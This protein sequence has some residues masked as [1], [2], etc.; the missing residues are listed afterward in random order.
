MKIRKTVSAKVFAANRNNAAKS[1]G[2][3]TRSGKAYASQNAIKHGIFARELYIT[4]EETGEFEELRHDLTAQLV[5]Q[6][7][8]QK[9]A[10]EEIL[11]CTW[12]SKLAGRLEMRALRSIGHETTNAL[13]RDEAVV[14]GW[15]GS[16]RQNL[17]AGLR[18]L[19]V[20]REGIQKDGRVPESLKEPLIACFGAHLYE[21]LTEYI[22]VNIDFI[23]ITERNLRHAETYDLPLPDLNDKGPKVVPDI[24][25]RWNMALK[26][27]DQEMRH[28]QDLDKSYEQRFATSRAGP[29]TDFA[30]R[31]FSSAMRDL[32]RA[33]D[34]LAHLKEHRM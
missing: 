5:P 33:I 34:R 20:L 2:P 1:T 14:E 10:V 26:L 27:V 16:N 4:A 32:H 23:L 17:Q 28:L 11:F 9:L 31:Y 29:T 19:A 30:P 3:K 24:R 13:S 15:Y 8:L 6:T 12:R 22:P 18:F 25:E 7:H 21:Q